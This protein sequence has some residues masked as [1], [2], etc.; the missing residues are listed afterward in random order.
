MPFNLVLTGF[1]RTVQSRRYNRQKRTWCFEPPSG[2][3]RRLATSVLKAHI[4]LAQQVF[5]KGTF[6]HALDS[7]ARISHRHE[8]AGFDHGTGHLHFI[9]ACMNFRSVCRSPAQVW[10]SK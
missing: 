8:A 3:R 6:G 7:A 4:A 1:G 10:D 2:E 9:S 5:P